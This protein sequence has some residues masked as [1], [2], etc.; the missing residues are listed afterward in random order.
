MAKLLTTWTPEDKSFWQSTGKSI[1][2]RNLWLSVPA[3]LLA[4]AVWQV[5][6]VTLTYLPNVGFKYSK[7]ELFTLA[8]LPALSG[9]TL[10]IVYSFV[11]PIFG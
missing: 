4:F 6:S 3:L 5:L 9:A 11:V 1:A 8:G 10:R 2:R 7:E